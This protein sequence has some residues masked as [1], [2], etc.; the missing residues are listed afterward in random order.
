[1]GSITFDSTAQYTLGINFNPSQILFYGAAFRQDR[2]F[3]VTAASA[4]AGAVYTNNGASFTVINTITGGTTLLTTSLGTPAA[5]GTLTKSSGT[6]DSTITFASVTAAS[7]GVRAQLIGN[8]QLGQSYYFQP[9][10]NRSVTQG[11]QI[12]NVIQ[13]SNMFLIDS[14]TSPVT[15]RD[16]VDEGHLIDAEYPTGTIRARATVSTYGLG[17]VKIDTQYR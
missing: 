3:T 14:S 5:S 9:Q 4:T 13:S 8:A 7:F 2:T 11:G 12:Q 10:T 1:M 6:G 15:V 17:Y 16:L